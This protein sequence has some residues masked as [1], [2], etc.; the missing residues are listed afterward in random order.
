MNIENSIKAMKSQALGKD[1]F[2]LLDEEYF[3]EEDDYIKETEDEYQEAIKAL[4]DI[5]DN[6][7]ILMDEQSQCYMRNKIYAVHFS[8]ECGKYSGFSQVLTPGRLDDDFSSLVDKGLFEMPG[9]ER[10]P[11]YL[12]SL[13]RINQIGDE[14]RAGLGGEAE[15]HLVSIEC[16]MEERIYHAAVM[17]FYCGY[18]SSLYTI[19][20]VKPNLPFSP[21]PQQLY[22]EWSLGLIASYDFIEG[23][24]RSRNQVQPSC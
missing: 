19:E 15:E 5:P 23:Q 6:M 13:D 10:H 20:H 1:F 8:Y 12:K 16:A 7:R 14:L 11:T 21:L 18:R 2:R 9:M 4:A 22:T 3:N 24:R 17:A